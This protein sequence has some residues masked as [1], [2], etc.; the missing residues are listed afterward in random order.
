MFGDRRR[1]EARP[2]NANL[3]N[4]LTLSRIAAV[5]VICLLLVLD[6]ATG[7]RL[8][9]AVYVLACLTDFLDGWLA[10]LR[11]QQSPFGQMLDPIADK[12]LIASLLLV[13]AGIDRLQGFDMLPAVVILCREVL[14]SGLREFLAHLQVGVPVTRLAK[15][16]TTVQMAA[17]GFLVLGGSGP[18][19]GPVDV[20]EIGVWGLW[21]AAALTFVTGYDYLRAS[22]SHL[23]A[24]RT[25]ERRRFEI[26]GGASRVDPARDAR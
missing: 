16:K 14:V 13:L 9:F 18:P 12:L 8:A 24:D 3:P 1:T 7:D 17:L 25:A 5:P 20:G 23:G 10:R 2:M 6:S 26:G 21:A 15:W 11:R 4:A 22:L 19:L